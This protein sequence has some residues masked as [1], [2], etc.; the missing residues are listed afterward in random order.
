M[1][2]QR[3]PVRRRP[4]DPVVL[5]QGEQ[6]LQAEITLLTT[7]IR[8]LE[9]ADSPDATHRSRLRTYQDMLRS[10]QEMLLILQNTPAALVAPPEQ[11]LRTP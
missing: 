7:W 10:R 4:P 3:K 1:N 2:D 6:Q 9:V 8:T 11:N 5:S